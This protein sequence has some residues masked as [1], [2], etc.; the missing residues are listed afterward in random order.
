[1]KAP[2]VPSLALLM[3]ITSEMPSSIKVQ[4][5]LSRSMIMEPPSS[6]PPKKMLSM[7]SSLCARDAKLEIS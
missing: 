5:K 7:N 4:Q 2:K 6:I 3:E 1:M